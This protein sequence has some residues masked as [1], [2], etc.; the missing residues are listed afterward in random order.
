MT[1]ALSYTDVCGIC[2]AKISEAASS[3]DERS[4]HDALQTAEALG[5]TGTDELK[6]ALAGG[7]AH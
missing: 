5:L 2:L 3:D 7:P 4:L 1:D 6:L